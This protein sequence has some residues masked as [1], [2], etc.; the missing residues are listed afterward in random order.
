MVFHSVLTNLHSYQQCTEKVNV[1]NHHGDVNQTHN[2]ISSHPCQNDYHPKESR[3][4]CWRGCGERG[5]HVSLQAVLLDS[6][7]FPLST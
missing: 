1:T 3:G 4:Q 2:E 7:P 6:V 5:L